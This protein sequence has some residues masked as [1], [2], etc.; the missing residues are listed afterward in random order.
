MPRSPRFVQLADL[1]VV[2]RGGS[3]A[4]VPTDNSRGAARWE[5]GSQEP[6]ST[7]RAGTWANLGPR[8]LG[9][10]ILS[11]LLP[12]C[13]VAGGSDGVSSAVFGPSVGWSVSTRGE[14]NRSWRSLYKAC[15]C[16]FLIFIYRV[17]LPKIAV[18]L[19]L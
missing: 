1:N 10:R 13:P 14:E 18:M 6:E 19:C 12:R 4:P 16:S 7:C 5:V 8:L 3:A 17:I 9:K 11:V 15:L 2:P